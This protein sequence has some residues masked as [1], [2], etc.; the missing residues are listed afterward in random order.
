MN[1]YLMALTAQHPTIREIWLIGSR[2][3]GTSGPSSDWDFL[4]FGTAHTLRKLRSESAFDRADT[5][6]LIVYDGDRF[7]SPWPKG[8]MLKQGSLT[9]WKWTQTGD[10]TA[11]YLATKPP[12]ADGEMPC[13]KIA[14]ATR[15]W[16]RA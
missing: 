7:E 8:P 10:D 6:L 15:A 9:S 2:A 5:D 1:P 12:L 13:R 16:R 11:T 14:P 4:V 3:D